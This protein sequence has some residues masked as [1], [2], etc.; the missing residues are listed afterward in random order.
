VNTQFEC[1]FKHVDPWKQGD[2]MTPPNIFNFIVN[3]WFW[4]SHNYQRETYV[5]SSLTKGGLAFWPLVHVVE[6]VKMVIVPRVLSLNV[7]T[8]S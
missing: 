4:N 2:M 1:E 7:V 3:G 8:C 5:A 6:C